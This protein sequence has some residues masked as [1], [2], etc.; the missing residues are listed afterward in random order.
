MIIAAYAGCGKTTFA[1]DT[2]NSIE[3][4]K[5]R[6]YQIEKITKETESVLQLSLD[7]IL[8][9]DI[10]RI[11]EETGICIEEHIR[12]FMIYIA[13]HPEI[14]H[15]AQ[16]QI[17]KN[18]YIDIAALS[19]E[20]YDRMARTLRIDQAIYEA[21][22]EFRNGGEAIVVEEAFAMLNEKY[23]GQNK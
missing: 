10:Q 18:G 3:F 13:E 20:L 4:L 6:R 9:E 17:T 23:Q 1:K 15:R 22:E 19:A 7:E 14:A 12:Q 21:E 5:D 16:E 11:F 8:E 2:W